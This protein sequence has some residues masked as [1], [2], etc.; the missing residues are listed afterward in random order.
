M[1]DDPTEVLPAVLGVR[2]RPAEAS[3]RA[4]EAVVPVEAAVMVS[5]GD[6][7]VVLE[8]MKLEPPVTAHK[9]GTV[10]GLA[11]SVGQTVTAGAAIC[12]IALRRTA[13]R[14]GHQPSA[15]RRE[16][17]LVAGEAPDAAQ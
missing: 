10:D 7:I 9:D 16:A 11:V 15:E 5:T 6:V 17:L 2:R 1:T 8:A 4:N 14:Q 13:Y 12:Q 3:R